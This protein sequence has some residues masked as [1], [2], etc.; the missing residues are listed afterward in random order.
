MVKH[1][2]RFQ[3][4]RRKIDGD[5]ISMRGV[6]VNMLKLNGQFAVCKLPAVNCEL[7]KLVCDFS[8][9]NFFH[10]SVLSTDQVFNFISH[11]T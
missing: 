10:S 6:F 8:F 1:A 9:D 3:F 7:N 5:F 2:Q 11:E 4:I